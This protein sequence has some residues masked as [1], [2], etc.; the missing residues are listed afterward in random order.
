[1]RLMSSESAAKLARKAYVRTCVTCALL[2]R[3]TFNEIV[4]LKERR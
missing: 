4:A 3:A 1:M 2:I